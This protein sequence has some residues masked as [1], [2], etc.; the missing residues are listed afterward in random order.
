MTKNPTRIYAVTDGTTT[1]LVRV[2]HPS[3]AVSHVARGT[4]SVRVATQDDL[5]ELLPAGVAV[6]TIKAEQA[7]LPET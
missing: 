4:Y 5:A 7:E 3:T 1:R 6:E 2:L